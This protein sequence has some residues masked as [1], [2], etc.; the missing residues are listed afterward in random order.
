MGRALEV[1]DMVC[2]EQ[3]G[4]QG[5]ELK[6]TKMNIDDLVL[7]LLKRAKQSKPVDMLVL[8]HQQKLLSKKLKRMRKAQLGNC[9]VV[10][11]EVNKFEGQM[12]TVEDLL[13]IARAKLRRLK[14]SHDQLTAPS[15]QSQVLGHSNSR[16][17][18]AISK[19]WVGVMKVLG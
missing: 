14:M 8:E 1:F 13:T 7:G 12:K 15:K 11:L 10:R 17:S 6:V 4:E 18:T 2:Q 19:S 9:S 3:E 5:Q 16:Q